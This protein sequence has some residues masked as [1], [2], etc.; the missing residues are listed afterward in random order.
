MIR[1]QYHPCY[2]CFRWPWCYSPWSPW[3][4]TWW[5]CPSCPSAPPTSPPSPARPRPRPRPS[6]ASQT[7]APSLLSR[8]QPVSTFQELSYF[9]T[10]DVFCIAR[11]FKITHMYIHVRRKVIRIYCPQS[12]TFFYDHY[13]IVNYPFNS[14]PGLS[15]LPLSLVLSWVLLRRNFRHVR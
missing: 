2:A 4:W 14:R 11:V 9:S 5:T 7:S 6:P 8:N 12:G 15:I 3:P 13:F 1:N 10:N